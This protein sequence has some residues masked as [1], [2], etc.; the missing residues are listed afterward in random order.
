MIFRSL[1]FDGL[2]NRGVNDFMMQDNELYE[3]KNCYSDRIGRLIKTPGYSLS[4]NGQVINAKSVNFLHNYYDPAAGN[5]YLL[6]GSDSGTDYILKYRTTGAW[7]SVLGT[8]SGAAGAE[9]S[10]ANY[11]GKAFIVGHDSGTFLAPATLEGTTYTTSAVTDTDLTNMP[12]GKFI[13]RYRDLLYVL[14]AYVGSTAFPNRAYLSPEPV[15]LAIPAPA[16]WNTTTDF[17]DVGYD[18]GEYITG[19]AEAFDRLVIF[20]NN[21]I[22][23]YDESSLKKIDDVGCDSYRSIAKINGVLYWFNRRGFWR[24]TGDL[25]ELISAKAQDIIEAITQTTL[26]SVVAS[27]FNGFEYRAYIGTVTVEGVTYTNAWFCWDTRKE[28]CY[29]RCT[30][31][32]A[33]SAC[34]FIEDS[35]KRMYFGNNNGYVMKFAEKI[36]GVYGDNGNPIDS[37]FTTKLIDNDTPESV[38]QTVKMTVFCENP[39]GT[40]IYTSDNLGNFK[41]ESYQV[42]S[43]SVDPISTLINGNRYRLKFAENSSNKSW[44]F[45]GVSLDTELSETDQNG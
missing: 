41:G 31:D 35:K 34:E 28:K 24:W 38:K 23:I 42:V 21:S 22:W 11:L 25:P 6:A 2:L 40:K 26:G 43:K 10:A 12:K 39:Q 5:S 20:K 33:A 16:G 29:I 14:N 44:I 7:S 36:D 27:V 3:V 4:V 32:V 30:Y 17:I 19:G 37:F 15:G 1:G 9:L 45:N 18:D 13:V 8:Y